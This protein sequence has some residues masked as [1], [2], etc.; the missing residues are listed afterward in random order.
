MK[1]TILLLVLALLLAPAG[2]A[3]KRTKESLQKQINALQ[4]EIENANQL[5]KETSKNKEVTLNQVTL[6]DKKIQSRQELIN[7]CNEQI[8]IL[9]KN[10]N[11]G[12]K[13]I[14]KLGGEIK[15]LQSELSKMVQFAYRNRSHYDRLEFFFASEDFNQALRRMRYIQQ[16]ADARQT[17]MQQIASAKKKV[18]D[19]V[20]A[21]RK[22]RE[23]QATLLAEEKAQQEA[24]KNERAELN[25]KVAQLKKKEGSIQQSIKDKQAQA[26][27]FQKQIDDIIAEEIRLANERAAAEAKKNKKSGTTNKSD[28]MA[29]TPA[30]KILSTTFSNNKGKLPWPVER[31]VVSSSFGKHA[32]AISDK[33]TITNNGIDIATTENAKARCVFEGVVVSVVRPSASNIGV[34]IRHGDYFTVYA[35]LDEVY[36]N[37]GDKVSTKQNIGKVHTDRYEGKTEIHFELRH[38]TE[39]LNPSIWLAK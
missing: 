16:F 19:E 5:L 13:N 18:S 2:Y 6:L 34:I 17:K 20:E 25:S 37:R 33:V 23:E 35:Q 14:K 27:K 26:K 11:Q 10:I 28:K 1:R 24:L 22:A 15:K 9:D 8:K 21:N 31:G 39:T 7:A 38:G 4:K 32:S 29:L 36:V 12:E 3:Q 30:E